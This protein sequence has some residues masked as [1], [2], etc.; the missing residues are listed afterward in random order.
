MPKRIQFKRKKGFKLPKNAMFVARPTKWGLPYKVVETEAEAK[1]AK[2]PKV[3][4]RKKAMRL[5][6]SDLKKKLK[7]DPEYLEPLKGKDLACYCKPE[8]DCHADILL[9]YAN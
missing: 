5:Y 2:D 1:A 8:L 4:P 9:K 6:E 3:M 7:S